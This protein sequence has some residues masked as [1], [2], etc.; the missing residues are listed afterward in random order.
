MIACLKASDCQSKSRL[1]VPRIKPGNLLKGLPCRRQVLH[2]MPDST[3]QEPSV[4]IVR[5][6]AQRFRQCG[7]RAKVVARQ[8]GLATLLSQCRGVGHPTTCY[9][10]SVAVPEPVWEDM[11]VIE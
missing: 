3:K 7:I 5:I 10:L 4:D 9:L 11:L 1:K 2:L 8:Q 6:L